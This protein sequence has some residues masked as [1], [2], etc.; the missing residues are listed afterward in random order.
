M[1]L[2][3]EKITRRE[4]YE[5]IDPLLDEI[6]AKLKGLHFVATIAVKYAEGVACAHTMTNCGDPKHPTIDD[7]AKLKIAR[8]I[9]KELDRGTKLIREKI[10]EVLDGTYGEDDAGEK[11]NAAIAKAESESDASKEL[12]I[13]E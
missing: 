12:E 10:G 5:V 4:A 13:V 11:E 6:D 3:S 1:E 2:N 9:T 8:E 7:E